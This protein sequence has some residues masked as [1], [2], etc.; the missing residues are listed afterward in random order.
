MATA[1]ER[2]LIRDV[3]TRDEY[4]KQLSLWH[5]FLNN[6]RRPEN[7]T[8]S[9]TEILFVFGWPVNSVESVR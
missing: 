7:E 1:E 4:K 2:E 3:I 9:Y 6:V 5:R 8:C